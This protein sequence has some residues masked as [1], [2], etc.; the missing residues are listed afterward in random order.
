MADKFSLTAQINLQAPKNT[1]QIYNQ[2]QKQLSNISINVGLTNARKAVQDITK[3]TKAQKQLESQSRKT[4][5]SADKMGKA[6]GSALKNVLRYDLARRVF[7]AFANTVEQGIGDAIRFNREMVKVAQVGNQTIKSLKGLTTQIRTL[8]KELGVSSMSLAKISVILKQT[9]IATKEVQVALR[10]L[11]LTDLAPTFD[12]LAD[13][14]ETAVAA[15]RQFRI[16]AKQFEGLFDKINRVAGNFAVEASD[17]GVA[18]KRAGG[19]FRSAG[20]SV[21]ELIALFTSVRATT[22][23]TAETIATGFRTIFTRLQ[24]PTT[25]KFLKQF[26]IE[27]QGLDGKFVGPYEAIGKLNAALKD[28]D[29]KDLRYSMIIEQLGGF[30][31]V[32]KVIPLIQEYGTSQ[33]VLN[34]QQRASG[35]LAK[36][37]AKAQE[38]L[39]VKMQ[40]LNEQVKEL[41]SEIANSAAFQTLANAALG[42]ASALTKVA[43]TIAPILPL[44]GV[45]FALKAGGWA[46]GKLGGGG[47]GGLN[48]A[49]GSARGDTTSVYG[50]NRGGRV[51]KRFSR[52]G[53]VPGTGNGDTVPALLEPGEFVIR[54]SAAQAFGSKLNK[55]NKYE[56]GGIVG[57]ES[58]LKAHD[59]DSVSI[60]AY[61]QKGAYRTSTR[62]IG[63]DAAELNKKERDAFDAVG[64]EHPADMGRDIAQDYISKRGNAFKSQ[65]FTTDQDGNRVSRGLSSDGR[66]RPLFNAPALGKE[67]VD[68][69]VGVKGDGKFSMSNYVNNSPNL[70]KKQRSGLKGALGFNEGGL[71]P[72]LLTPGEFVVNKKSAQRMGY[73]KLRSMNKYAGGGKV[74]RFAGGG[75]VTSGSAAFDNL[76]GVFGNVASE[77]KSAGTA[78]KLVAGASTDVLGGFTQFYAIT[79]AATQG[80]SQFVQS[81]FGESESVQKAF[82]IVGEATGKF[83]G[84]IGGF[85]AI[86]KGSPELA[87]QI[88]KSFDKVANVVT[89]GGTGKLD[90]KIAELN[91]TAKYQFG[92]AKSLDTQIKRLGGVAEDGVKAQAKLTKLNATANKLSLQ[93]NNITNKIRN[94]QSAD[95]T[96]K[97]LRAS[98]SQNLKNA[99]KASA[100]NKVV[101]ASVEQNSKQ[102]TSK[103]K[104]IDSQKAIKDGFKTQKDLAKKSLDKSRDTVKAL[105]KS[106][107]L[108]SASAAAADVNQQT[109]L[110][111]KAAAVRNEAT[112]RGLV[113]ENVEAAQQAGP[114][115]K[116]AR[117]QFRKQARISE[118]NARSEVADQKLFQGEADKFGAQGAEARAKVAG[119]DAE[120]GKEV[121]VRQPAA[122]AQMNQANRG[123]IAADTEM[124]KLADS[125]KGLHAE[126][127]ELTKQYAKNSQTVKT[128]VAA[129]DDATKGIASAQDDLAKMGVSGQPGGVNQ[130]VADLETGKAKV[131]AN[132]QG[133]TDEAAGVKR[134]VDAGK[135]AT[136]KVP[137]LKNL[138]VEAIKTAKQAKNLARGMKIAANAL[139][140]VVLALPLIAEIGL[141]ILGESMTQAAESA[142]NTAES[143][144]EASES[145]ITSQYATGATATALGKLIGYV[146]M[147]G[148]AFMVLSSVATLLVGTKAA[149]TAVGGA[150]IAVNTWLTAAAGSAAAGLTAMSLPVML[151]VGALLLL[152]AGLAI[153]YYWNKKQAEAA[154]MVAT[155]KLGNSVKELSDGIQKYNDGIISADE[156]NRRA[157][158]TRSQYDEAEMAGVGSEDRKKAREEVRKAGDAVFGSL[159]GRAGGDQEKADQLF[160]KF[161]EDFKG[162][163]DPETLKAFKKN[164]DESVASAKR[165]REAADAMAQRAKE[166]IHLQ[167]LS[168]VFKEASLRVKHF[169]DVI[170]AATD[171]LSGGNIGSLAELFNP[172]EKS[173]GGKN[174]TNNMIDFIGTGAGGLVG[175]D[176]SVGLLPL[177]KDAKDSSM[178]MQNAGSA[179]LRARDADSLGEGGATAAIMEQLDLPEGK[180]KDE[181]EGMLGKMNEDD[182]KDMLINDPDKLQ[183]MIEDRVSGFTDVFK[184]AYEMLDDYN[185][186]LASAYATQMSLQ[187]EVID[188]QREIIGRRGDAQQR[189]N[190]AGRTRTYQGI[191]EDQALI[192]SKLAQQ[193]AAAAQ[194]GSAGVQEV[195]ASGDV[196][197]I[198]AAYKEA[199]AALRKTNDEIAKMEEAI[200]KGKFDELAGSAENAK[201]KLDEMKDANQALKDDMQALGNVL[202]N[203]ADIQDRL[204]AK[205]REQE[206]LGQK[207]KT[208]KQLAQDARYGTAEQKEESQRLINAIQIARTEGIDAVAP[209]LQRTVIPYLEQIDGDAGAQ[210]VDAGINEWLGSMG[211]ATVGP[212]GV[213]GV[214][215]ISP[216]E[217]KLRQE[218]LKLEEDSIKAQEALNSTTKTG[219]DNVVTSIGELKTTFETELRNLLNDRAAQAAEEDVAQKKAVASKTTG[220]KNALAE[221]AAAQTGVDL[222]NLEGDERQAA[223][224]EA[225]DKFFGGEQGEDRLKFLQDGTIKS[226]LEDINE[227]SDEFMQASITGSASNYSGTQSLG[228]AAKQIIDVEAK[229]VHRDTS[230][231]KQNFNMLAGNFVDTSGFDEGETVYSLIKK[232]RDENSAGFEFEVDELMNEDVDKDA[233]AAFKKLREGMKARFMETGGD[234]ER[235][236]D[237]LTK[238]EKDDIDVEEFFNRVNEEMI[239]N[240]QKITENADFAQSEA[241][242]LGIKD[243][244]AATSGNVMEAA[245]N[246]KSIEDLNKTES[247]AAA[248]VKASELHLQGLHDAGVVKENSIAVKN[249]HSDPHIAEINATAKAI[250]AAMGGTA[251]SAAASVGAMAGGAGMNFEAEIAKVK[252]GLSSGKGISSA[253]PEQKAALK[254]EIFS[255][256][257]MD[258]GSGA[259]IDPKDPSGS[260]A[261]IMRG[262]GGGITAA[263]IANF[264]YSSLNLGSGSNIMTPEEFARLSE[265]GSESGSGDLVAQA[266]ALKDKHDARKAGAGASSSGTMSVDSSGFGASVERFSQNLGEV[267][268]MLGNPL[269]IE[270]GGTIDMN[271][272]L[273]GAEF[274]KDAQDGFTKLAGKQVTAGINNFIKH[275]LKNQQVK[276]KGD[277]VDVG[278]DSGGKGLAGAGKSSTS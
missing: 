117:K 66:L 31:Q 127:V 233:K 136:A 173:T 9:G 275:G 134:T 2:I 242:R 58:I 88:S 247:E 50:A 266:N 162:V 3:I 197:A 213:A 97:E 37:A 176:A 222:T 206:R 191:D 133:V 105:E 223:L 278:G 130:A 1:K 91:K 14:T 122:Q 195:A 123:M 119:I 170:E 35:S 36:D 154:K 40:K 202:G 39:A 216:E 218:I 5:T 53:W 192:D 200:R 207:R 42:F 237:I 196:G 220:Q 41:F 128:N 12:N 241:E 8:S 7:S 129:Y 182:L 27:L 263:D 140:G 59:G 44:L 188:Q 84:V 67:L 179:V 49:L 33:R 265:Y 152:V 112:Y 110:G 43:K 68:A 264:D 115:N 215:A 131:T 185:S 80:L 48:S 13:T 232:A 77:A 141:G 94:I 174:R 261:K 143:F 56:K 183:K 85:K 258:L 186:Q 226:G 107:A 57:I 101:S 149:E 229:S 30:R 199:E 239:A 126:N 124:K 114:Q 18:I 63:F 228:A 235:F 19:A 272:N 219:L 172:S 146:G 164:L 75:A 28:L 20:G 93:R 208:L 108:P 34:E 184:E 201:K 221:C 148:L 224:D 15:M 248:A 250:L 78:L 138:R 260:F 137:E 225:Y 90:K 120:I 98:R 227:M 151:L 178:A 203:Y 45:F 81:I 255:K 92:K 171:P 23:E 70:N 86:Q 210:A 204:N 11:A 205:L 169:G 234:A 29:P 106:K 193:N 16:E 26:G 62:L 257:G 139:K 230:V 61:P 268:A 175:E 198:G 17:I 145:A 161:S 71:V 251:G 10:A 156:L 4:S 46:A 246:V 159:S 214:T 64:A 76:V 240:A 95:K 99:L 89:G 244:S 274:L 87:G 267:S 277:W 249:N 190:E 163:Y 209:E 238:A 103:L 82:D 111:K 24:R 32:S 276:E 158:K 102:I 254:K 252:A 116:R 135:K 25:I 231:A 21:E 65:F 51:P 253:S 189:F 104:D 217:E 236:E 79:Q 256:M 60:M 109:A 166:L 96:V 132:I 142:I 181:I 155:A 73:G 38:T 269:T 271:V 100:D 167:N 121:N 165:M 212:D 74:Q 157:M 72:A 150:L 180:I 52:G 153:L 47:L 211:G 243:L 147:A 177:V 273:N 187:Q 54:K 168:S 69:G 259:S 118:L 160:A 113:T 55:I 245:D 144:T 125:A 22:R 83:A 6:F 262:S 270:I 194:F